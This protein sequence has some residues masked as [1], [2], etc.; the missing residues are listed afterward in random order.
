MYLYMLLARELKARL[1]GARQI[2]MY[3]NITCRANSIYLSM[4]HAG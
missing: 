3:F 1:R 2:D 4:K